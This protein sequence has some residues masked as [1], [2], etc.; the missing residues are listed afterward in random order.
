MNCGSG[1]S[2]VYIEWKKGSLV[3]MRRIQGKRTRKKWIVDNDTALTT[4]HALWRTEIP[5]ANAM[6]E[7]LIVSAFSRI[8]RTKRF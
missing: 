4:A 8:G 3:R 1:G 5:A 7:I 2:R 6:T